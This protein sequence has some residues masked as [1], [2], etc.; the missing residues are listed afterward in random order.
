MMFLWVDLGLSAGIAVMF[1]SSDE[2]ASD[3]D[4]G[5]I[6]VAHFERGAFARCTE[7]MIASRAEKANAIVNSVFKFVFAE[8]QKQG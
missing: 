3:D 2:A 8:A 5:L 4:C 7:Q 6:N 1:K